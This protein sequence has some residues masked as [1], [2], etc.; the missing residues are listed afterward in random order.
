MGFCAICAAI[1]AGVYAI[2]QFAIQKMIHSDAIAKSTATARFFENSIADIDVIM[3]G[4]EP[5]PESIEFIRTAI[6]GTGTKRIKFYSKSGHLLL[7]SEP[8]GLL[9][10]EEDSLGSHNPQAFLAIVAD[11]PFVELNLGHGNRNRQADCRNLCAPPAQW[12]VDRH[13]RSLC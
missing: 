2:D 13:C 5:K 8:A 6:K 1:I 11:Q 7:D 10:A 4:A 3:F 9:N 12:T